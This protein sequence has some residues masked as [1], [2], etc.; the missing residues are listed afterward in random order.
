MVVY[1]ISVRPRFGT[2]LP[3]TFLLTVQLPPHN[4]NC[5][6]II[7]AN[8]EFSPRYGGDTIR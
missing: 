8:F 3:P 5:W 7:A 4:A 2:P 1:I 6:Q